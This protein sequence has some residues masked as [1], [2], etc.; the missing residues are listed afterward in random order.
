MTTLMPI[1]ATNKN[2]ARR[3]ARPAIN[4]ITGGPTKNPAKPTVETA[5]KATPGDMVLDFPAAL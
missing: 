1:T 3:V 5:A 2:D 4:P